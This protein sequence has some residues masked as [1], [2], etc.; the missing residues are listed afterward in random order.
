MLLI[1]GGNKP[2]TKPINKTKNLACHFQKRKLIQ[3]SDCPRAA[4]DIVTV[5]VLL[6]FKI[7]SWKKAL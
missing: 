7:L 3:K 2:E 1:W 6:I 5:T 4:N